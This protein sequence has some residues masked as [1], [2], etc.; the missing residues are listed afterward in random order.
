MGRMYIAFWETTLEKVKEVVKLEKEGKIGKIPEGVKSIGNYVTPDCKGVEVLEVEDEKA[1]FKY[2]I[3]FLPWMKREDVYP[4][5]TPK[6]F[7]ELIE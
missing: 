2:V 4:A 3:Q 1:L 7:L 5:L 6:E